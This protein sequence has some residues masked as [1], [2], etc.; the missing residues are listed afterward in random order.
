M[1][2]KLNFPNGFENWYE[3]FYEV[4]AAISQN[5]YNEGNA[6]YNL[7][8]SEGT[9]AM[10][11]LARIWTD[12]FEAAH[13]GREWDGDFFDTLEL[14]IRDKEN[15]KEAAPSTPAPPVEETEKPEFTNAGSSD[16][17]INKPYA[18][19]LPGWKEM[20]AAFKAAGYKLGLDLANE[21]IIEKG[22]VFI[23][24]KTYED[25]PEHLRT[26]LEAFQEEH[27]LY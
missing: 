10:Y 23:D 18:C 15:E 7:R 21:V 8:Q 19:E 14:F 5:S 16:A 11:D 1:S 13:V 6:S 27:V 9:A 26:M 25:V 22:G 2:E 24:E 12:E 3:T 4:A 17:K 20:E